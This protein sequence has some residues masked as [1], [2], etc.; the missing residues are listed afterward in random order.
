M[1]TM[2]LGLTKLVGYILILGD[3]PPALA[4]IIYS[5][6][7][8]AIYKVRFTLALGVNALKCLIVPILLGS[9]IE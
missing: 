7:S 5:I 1:E 2:I 3:L 4:L 6:V 9:P 8:I